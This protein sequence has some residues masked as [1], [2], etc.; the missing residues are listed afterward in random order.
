MF[1]VVLSPKCLKLLLYEGE[2]LRLLRNSPQL[3]HFPLNL[4]LENSHMLEF[5]W[6]MSLHQ[7]PM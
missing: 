2:S 7:L 4:V 3:K 6:C 5:V 1:G